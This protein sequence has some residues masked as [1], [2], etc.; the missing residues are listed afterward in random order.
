MWPGTEAGIAQ[1]PNFLPNPNLLLCLNAD[2][3]MLKMCQARIDAAPMIKNDI[4]SS[5]AAQLFQVKCKLV[6]VAANLL[7]IGVPIDHLNHAARRRGQYCLPEA[8]EERR[9]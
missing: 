1:F 8:S 4:I 5:G 3:V 7:A 2:G 9:R 6:R